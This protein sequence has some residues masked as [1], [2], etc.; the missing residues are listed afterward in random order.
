MFIPIDMYYLLLVDGLYR[1]AVP[2]VIPII[3]GIT[4]LTKT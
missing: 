1:Y 4:T 2:I 3:H